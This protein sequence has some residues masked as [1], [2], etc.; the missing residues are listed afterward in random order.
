ML[1][2]LERLIRQSQ[3]AHV[4]IA[5]ETQGSAT[6]AQ[7][8][9]MQ[10]IEE[11]EALFTEYGPE[12]LGITVNL[13]HAALASQALGQSLEEL[14]DC[15]AARARALELSHPEDGLDAHLPLRE[16]GWYWRYVVEGRF[17]G[18]PKILEYRDC[19][20]ADVVESLRM[21]EALVQNA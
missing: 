11:F 12:D 1:R 2:G 17:D 20:L 10:R 6:Q 8:L 19:E 15:V 3:E 9:L 16:D 5:I 14:L 4:P 7:H 13:A 18:L 21:C